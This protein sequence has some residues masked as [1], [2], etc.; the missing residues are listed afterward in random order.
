MLNEKSPRFRAFTRELCY[1]VAI[2]K[3]IFIAVC[4]RKKFRER[5]SQK[6]QLVTYWSVKRWSIARRASR[7]FILGELSK[8]ARGLKGTQRFFPAAHKAMCR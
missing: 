1:F 8:D 2:K 7:T 3:M 5:E 6:R 4:L